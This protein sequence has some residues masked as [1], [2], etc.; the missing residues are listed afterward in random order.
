MKKGQW[1]EN[2]LILTQ[3][4][5][6]ANVL[7]SINEE[8][9]YYHFQETGEEEGERSYDE[10]CAMVWLRT[11]RRPSECTTPSQYCCCWVCG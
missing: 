8:R 5:E 6:K 9:G 3:S 10:E 2:W 1:L 4:G 7:H 11:E